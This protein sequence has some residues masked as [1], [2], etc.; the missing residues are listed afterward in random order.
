MR[1][2]STVSGSDDTRRDFFNA[3]L[4]EAQ[5]EDVRQPNGCAVHIEKM[6]FI[7]NNIFVIGT[8]VVSSIK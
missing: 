3:S 1:G 2:P 7:A 5:P 4:A 8:Y 6:E